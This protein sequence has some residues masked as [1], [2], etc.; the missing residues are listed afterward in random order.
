MGLIDEASYLKVSRPV[1]D[2]SS[3]WRKVRDNTESTT[4][5]PE[6]KLDNTKLPFDDVDGE[7]VSKLS[8]MTR[9]SSVIR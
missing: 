8:K 1:I 2:N 3:D 4:A 6:V 9:S 7:E 5:V